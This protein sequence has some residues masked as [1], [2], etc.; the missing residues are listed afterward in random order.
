M[1]DDDADLI[2]QVSDDEDGN[3]MDEDHHGGG[4]GN[5]NNN[6][7]QHRSQNRG[8]SNRLSDQVG[9]DEPPLNGYTR[10]VYNI[11]VPVDGDISS[12]LATTPH[13]TRLL[14]LTSSF[15]CTS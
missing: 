5:N 9:D 12:M 7:K 6:N 11:Y 1:Y 8:N 10:Y 13:N 4:G 14:F 2:D 3:A 15:V